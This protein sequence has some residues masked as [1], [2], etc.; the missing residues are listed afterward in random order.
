M[1]TCVCAIAKMEN[2]YLREWVEYYKNLGFT[3]I[4]LYDNNDPDGE[5]PAEVIG[6]FIESGF[7]ELVDVRGERNY[8]GKAYLDC[9]RRACNEFD[10]FFFFDIDEYLVLESKYRNCVDN[11]L[12]EPFFDGADIIRVRWHMMSDSGHVR[13]E[14]GDYSLVDR[15]TIPVPNQWCA[16]TKAIVR[17]GIENLSFDVDNSEA[18]S[19]IV[20]CDGINRAVDCCGNAVPNDTGNQELTFENA[21]LNH[22]Y[23]KTVEEYVLNRLKKGWPMKDDGMPD[24]NKDFFF[25]FNERTEEKERLF[26]ELLNR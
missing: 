2:N 25:Y 15:F 10:W 21:Y 16:W 4:I 20:R 19:H 13:I 14:N 1:R 11:F 22:Y 5:S 18:S 6:D 12:S 24:F 3:K 9:Y 7:V 23:T 8:Q 26:D 17:G